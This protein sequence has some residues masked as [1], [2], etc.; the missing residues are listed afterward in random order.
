MLSAFVIVA[1]LS[2]CAT[3]FA[4]HQILPPQS[5]FN[6]PAAL[7]LV[8]GAQ[9]PSQTYTALALELQ[10]AATL[11]EIDLWIAN[12][13][14]PIDLPV[15]GLEK[16]IVGAL[17]SLLNQ[18]L[19]KGASLFL[20][21]TP[22]LLASTVLPDFDIGETPFLAG[23]SLGGTKIQ[24]YINASLAISKTPKFSFKG[25]VLLCAPLQRKYRADKN[26]T[27]PQIPV[28]TLG[29]SDDGLMRITRMAEA[30]YHGV[31]QSPSAETKFSQKAVLDTPVIVLEGVNHW[32]FASGTGPR[33]YTVRKNVRSHLINFAMFYNLPLRFRILL[34]LPPHPMHTT[35]LPKL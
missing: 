25:L 33:P 13:H 31:S 15:F 29:G 24:D 32:Q 26:G 30:F 1:V 9:A 17:N 19:P 8:G 34:L 21:G 35:E 10:A 18:G 5:T 7:V 23:H 3:A 12:A 4:G 6:N 22:K 20:A 11:K 14:S 2:V 16:I 28:L 27:F